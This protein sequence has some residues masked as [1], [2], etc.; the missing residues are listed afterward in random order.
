MKLEPVE[1]AF[2]VTNGLAVCRH[3]RVNAVFLLHYLI[4]DELRIS[5]NLETMDPELDRYSKAVDEGFIL[6]NI[7][8][9]WEM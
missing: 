9:G 2:Q 4:H 3:L 5:S 8:G 6:G 1:L 7:V